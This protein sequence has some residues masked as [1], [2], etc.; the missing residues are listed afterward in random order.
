M[1]HTC[2]LRDTR[3]WASGLSSPGP[4]SA[5]SILS[6]M[7]DLEIG[8]LRRHQSRQSGA[9][10]HLQME[11]DRLRTVLEVEGI[12]LDFSEEDDGSSSDDAPP[13]SPP[14]A[15]AGPSQRRR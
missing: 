4:S 8:R 15:V 12:P 1:P 2:L 7:R 3:S 13:Y 9:M 11:V 10:A 6:G 14:Q 5:G